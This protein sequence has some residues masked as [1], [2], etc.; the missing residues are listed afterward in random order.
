MIFRR[1]WL[2]LVM[3][4][5][6]LYIWWLFQSGAVFLQPDITLFWQKEI[7]PWIIVWWLS[8]MPLITVVLYSIMQ[9][10]FPYQKRIMIGW[11]ATHLVVSQAILVD[12]VSTNVFAADISSCIAMVLVFA[13]LFDSLISALVI[14]QKKESE[15]E[16]IEV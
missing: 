7:H 6:C 3:I 8:F 12:T 15:L 1:W 14:A 16:I 13:L 11:W 2:A 10:I 4:W 9:A 5:Y